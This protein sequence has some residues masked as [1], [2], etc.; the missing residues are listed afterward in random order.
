MAAAWD[1][2]TALERWAR[3]RPAPVL[4]LDTSSPYSYSWNLLGATKGNHTLTAKAYDA[5]GN[6]TTST[7]ITVKVN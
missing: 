3:G 2:R 4:G 7:A 6:V 1:V 5:A